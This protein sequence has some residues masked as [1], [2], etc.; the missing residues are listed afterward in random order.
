MLSWNF[1][2]GPSKEWAVMLGCTHYFFASWHAMKS[3]I[4]WKWLQIELKEVKPLCQVG[5][6]KSGLE[7]QVNEI[8]I[9]DNTLALE[10]GYQM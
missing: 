3:K 1:K 10:K 8:R 2:E 9:D 4:C 7:W 5:I 6:P